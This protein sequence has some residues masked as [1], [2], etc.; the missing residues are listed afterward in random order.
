MAKNQS[1]GDILHATGFRI[2]VVG[3]GYLR[4]NLRS[5][6]N[7][8]NATLALLPMATVTNREPAV[9]ARF[10]EQGIQLEL[11]TVSINE[12]FRIS[13]IIIFAKPV[14]SDYPVGV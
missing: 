12:I 4:S 1:S 9:L 13:K 10:Q 14:S 2:R 11:K 5:F 3:A 8:R 6:D 7:V